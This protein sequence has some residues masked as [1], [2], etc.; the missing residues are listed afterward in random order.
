MDQKSV[1]SIKNFLIDMDGVIVRG[2]QIIP[3]ADEFIARLQ[4][5]KKEYLVLTNNSLYAPR[6]L[7]H[8]LQSIDLHIPEERIFTSAMA[9]AQFLQNQRPDGTAYVIGESGLTSAIHDAGYIISEIN[10]DYVVL[11]ETYAY[12]YEMITRG[13]RLIELGARFI[14]TNPDV[15]GPTRIGHSPWL[16]SD[17][18]VDRKSDWEKAILCRQAK[19]FDDAHS[20]ELSRCPFRGHCHG[21]RPDGY[22]YCRRSR[23]R[24]A[25]HPRPDRR[26]QSRRCRALPVR[27]DLDFLT[28]SRISRLDRC[29]S[30]RLFA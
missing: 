12:N 11:G 1:K 16:R 26:N 30:K 22:R 9:T 17:G 19:S 13:I 6:D 2:N 15:S 3:G 5:Q 8:R 21:R 25:H 7:A 27:S 14:A 18:I 24:H 28:R 23:E 10:P 4:K 20:P 29:P